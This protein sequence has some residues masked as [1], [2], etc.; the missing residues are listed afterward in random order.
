MKKR[1]Y[2]S[3]TRMNGW[4][5]PHQI[6]QLFFTPE[7]QEVASAG[8]NDGASLT[9]EGLHGTGLRAPLDQVTVTLYMMASPGLGVCLLY[10]KWDGRDRTKQSMNSKGDLSRLSEF[11]KSLHGDSMSVGLFIPI[12]VAWKAVGEFIQTDGKLPASIEWIASEDLPPEAF[13]VP[14][15]PNLR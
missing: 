7:G 1:S 14:R 3:S 12:S 10:T 9:I 5:T 11:V 6:Q 4:P 15:P 8:G 2:F 13:P